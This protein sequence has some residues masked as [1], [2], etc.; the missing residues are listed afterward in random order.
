MLS[1]LRERET[2]QEE[3]GLTS[4]IKLFCIISSQICLLLKLLTLLRTR[5]NPYCK[6]SPPHHFRNGQ[7]C[8]HQSR[9]RISSYKCKC[10]MV[11]ASTVLNVITKLNI[12]TN[13][14]WQVHATDHCQCTLALYNLKSAKFSPSNWTYLT[15]QVFI[16]NCP[17]A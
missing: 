2:Q 8:K 9:H 12:P 7:K 14:C 13:F 15:V 5:L 16:S 4:K 3:R 1:S 17:V 11:S 6:V 10:I